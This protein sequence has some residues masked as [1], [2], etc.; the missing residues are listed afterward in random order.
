[1]ARHR[2]GV[3]QQ[4]EAG[5]LGCDWRLCSTSASSRVSAVGASPGRARQRGGCP[6]FGCGQFGSQAFGSSALTR[7]PNSALGA[8][9]L[10]QVE[11]GGQLPSP[12]QSSARRS[13][14]VGRLTT[15]LTRPPGALVPAWMPLVPLRTSTRSLLASGSEVSALIGRPSRR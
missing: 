8:E 2:A 5:W 7:A 10:R 1:M 13:V 12:T 14:A 6:R 3:A 15:R 11:A 4:A 9:A